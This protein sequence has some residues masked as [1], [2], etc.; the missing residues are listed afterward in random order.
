MAADLLKVAA[1][2]G[3]DPCGVSFHVGSQQRDPERW[4]TPV[5]EAAALFET[6]AAAGIRLRLVNLGGGFPA[7][8]LAPVPGIDRYAQA[9]GDAVGRHFGSAAPDL[10]VEPGRYLAGDAGVLCTEVVLVSRKAYGDARRWVFLDAGV[11]GGLAETLG[12]AIKYRIVTS[13]DDGRVGPVTIAGPTCDSM[14]VLYQSYEYHLPQALQAGDRVM[15]L[16]AGA[17]TRSYC[18]VGFNGFEPLPVF[19]A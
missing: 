5:A 10:I 4:D 8:Y 17:Y 14:D 1:T 2:L 15:F 18:S 9:I 11:F 6:L 16:S 19:C 3:L 7:R 12:E 13:V